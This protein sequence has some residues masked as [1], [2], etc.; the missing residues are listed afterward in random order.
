[1]KIAVYHNLPSGGG[2]RALT[3]MLAALHARHTVDVYSLYPETDGL[4]PLDRDCRHSYHYL[5]AHSK[6]S[7]WS[8]LRWRQRLRQLDKVQRQIAHEI[9]GRGYD[10]IFVANCAITQSPLV[11]KY[12]KT[13]TVFYC[14]EPRRS[15]YEFRLQQ[16]SVRQ[17]PRGRLAA[18]KE[19]RLAE[20]DRQAAQAATRILCNSYYSMESLKRAYGIDAT[21]C[22]MGVDV[23]ATKLVASADNYILSAG[24]FEPFKN[25]LQIV[26]ALAEITPA[27]RPRL[28]VAGD[29]YDSSYR[30][31]VEALARHR[32]V[33]LV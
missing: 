31:R 28:I 13:P 21:V 20:L 30:R 4:W 12:L 15:N 29:R 8:K 2:R 19:R 18:A 11:L 9:D 17:G 6:S 14:Q 33:E 3:K 7:L 22:Y 16:S 32:D 5:P 27:K 25:Q 24:A 26:E 23:P 10:V 1:L